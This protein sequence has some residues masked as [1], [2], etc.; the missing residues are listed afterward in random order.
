MIEHADA[1]QEP[2]LVNGDQF[3][4]ATIIK[5]TKGTDRLCRMYQ[6]AVK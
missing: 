2:L 6:A 5:S 1:E 3:G 4:N